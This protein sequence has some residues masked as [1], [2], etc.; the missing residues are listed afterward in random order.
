MV[1]LE[2]KKSKISKIVYNVYDK[3]IKP[4]EVALAGIVLNYQF[5]LGVNNVNKKN[6]VILQF[7]V[8]AVEIMQF[9]CFNGV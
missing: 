6:N 4:I 2:F 3:F 1:L 7:F 9:V 5:G 8:L